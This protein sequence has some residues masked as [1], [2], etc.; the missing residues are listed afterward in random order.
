M[1]MAAYDNLTT[2]DHM[3]FAKGAFTPCLGSAHAVT[4]TGGSATEK[5]RNKNMNFLM[6]EFINTSG[7]CNMASVC[8][9]HGL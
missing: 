7:Q 4:L 8:Q 9:L 1:Y 3:M 5:E 6:F 2:D